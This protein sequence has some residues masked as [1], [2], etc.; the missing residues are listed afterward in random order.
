MPH[1]FKPKPLSMSVIVNFNSYRAPLSDNISFFDGIMVVSVYF[2]KDTIAVE[3]RRTRVSMEDLISSIGGT[4]GVYAGMSIIT[5]Y[6]A[7]LYL[8]SGI[9]K[10]MHRRAAAAKKFSKQSISSIRSKKSTIH[11]ILS[12][13]ALDC[14]SMSKNFHSAFVLNGQG[15]QSPTE[16][17]VIDMET[18]ST[19]YE[20]KAS[21]FLDDVSTVSIS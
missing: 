3:E 20:A 8:L 9:A 17:F 14:L 12:G 19:P 4:L 7:F 18:P 10:L 1:F 11:S 13:S 21:L 6:Q 15:L 5:V 16:M 2:G